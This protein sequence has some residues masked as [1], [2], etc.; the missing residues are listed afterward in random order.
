MF[1]MSKDDQFFD[2]V[3]TIVV[4]RLYPTSTIFPHLFFGVLLSFSSQYTPTH[5]IQKSGIDTYVHF[6]CPQQIEEAIAIGITTMFGGGTGP[7]SGTSATTCTP[8]P[9][10]YELMLRSVYGYPMN[11]GFSG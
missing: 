8:S 4:C 2:H 7:S 1:R 9:N 10:H 6:I 3:C 11:F 5:D